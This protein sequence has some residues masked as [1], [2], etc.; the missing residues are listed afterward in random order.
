LFEGREGSA[1]D[2]GIFL[3]R[4]EAGFISELVMLR[5][6]LAQHPGRD[7]RDDHQSEARRVQFPQKTLLLLVQ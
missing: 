5:R 4:G 6:L 7:S 1:A 2:L 3:R